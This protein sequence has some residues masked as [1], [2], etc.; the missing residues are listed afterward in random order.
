MRKGAASCRAARS[1][2]IW[3]GTRSRPRRLRPSTCACSPASRRT[4]RIGP[5][6]TT[7]NTPLTDC[8]L[9]TSPSP[10]D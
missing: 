8:L 9:Y 10:R 5:K 7:D 1:C 6:H 3:R 2:R 4:Q